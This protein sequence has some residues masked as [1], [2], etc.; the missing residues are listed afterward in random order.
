LFVFAA[1]NSGQNNDGLPSYPAS[2]KAPN[3]ISVAATTNADTLAPFS[4]YG[5]TTVHLGAPGVNI[6]STWPNA[7]YAFASGTSM[8]TPHV[9]GAAMLLLSACEMNTAALKSTLLT[10]VDH[11]A[12]LAALTVSGGRLDINKA[13]L[14]CSVNQPGLPSMITTFGQATIPVGG[15]TSLSY[16]IR[17]PNAAVVLNGVGFTNNLP[18]GILVAT[19]NGLN[20]FCGGGSVT[21]LVG[22][23]TVSLRGATLLPGASCTFGLNV[24]GVTE[25]LKNNITGVVSSIEA[26]NGSA[27]S[28]T[29]MVASP[30]TLVKTF[31]GSQIQLFGPGNNTVLSFVLSNPDTFTTLSGLTFTDTLPAGLT[32]SI[33]NGLT[34]S[35]GGGTIAAD[36]GSNTISLSGATLAAGTSCTFSVNVSG[37]RIGVQTSTTS[38]VGSNEA[39]P[40]TPAVAITSVDDLFF[41]WFHS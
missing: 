39:V 31:A 17:N 24:I 15:A 35:C 4:S 32:V 28:A 5:P 9:S 19:P 10:N 29:L 12:S 8:A 6:L 11:L 7:S 25:G 16:T 14:S 38:T 37:T 41:M 13:M 1:G 22:L 2:Y 34:G 23:D 3:I 27:A 40:G 18:A 26:G 21:A 33:P 36:A 20:G 30:A